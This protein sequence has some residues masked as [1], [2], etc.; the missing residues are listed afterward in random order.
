MQNILRGADLPAKG[1]EQSEV[2]KFIWSVRRK[3][4]EVGQGKEDYLRL[5]V[6]DNKIGK[7]AV[8]Y[9]TNTHTHK[10]SST[11]FVIIE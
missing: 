8:D 11:P 4:D 10:C 9:S 5:N 3:A 2:E 7:L 6:F 1:R